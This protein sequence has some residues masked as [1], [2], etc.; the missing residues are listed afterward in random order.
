MTDANTPPPR[1]PGLLRRLLPLLVLA[2]GLAAFFAFGLDRHVS[3]DALRENRGRLLAWVAA[4]PL[5][6]PFVFGL[7]YVAATAFSLPI[8]LPLSLTAGFLFGLPLGLLVVVAGASLGAILVF[9]AART[10]FGENLLARAG[11]ALRRMEQGF[12]DNAVSY[13]LF[14]RLVPVF[15]FWMVNL[16]AAI[17]G[18]PLRVFVLTTFFGIMP[19][20]F[21]IV[22][23]GRGL[24]AVL[25]SGATPDAGSILTPDILLAL[26]LLGVLALVPAIYRKVKARRQPK[27][28]AP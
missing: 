22:N 14:L 28:A 16:A 12:R 24:G 25:D 27:G 11:P 8:A 6:A 3:F 26:A 13:M 5:L 17:F 4:Y 21:V 9:L 7:L 19:A 23:V 10:A 20:S 1:E 15:P 2:A 18:A